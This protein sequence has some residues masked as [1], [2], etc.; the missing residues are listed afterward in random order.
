MESLCAWQQR[1]RVG[2]STSLTE[3]GQHMSLVFYCPWAAI[4][5]FASETYEGVISRYSVYP[6]A[7][8]SRVR[9]F[10]LNA[11]RL[12]NSGSSKRNFVS[13]V[14]CV[15][16]STSSL[17]APQSKLPHSILLDRRKCRIISAGEKT[18]FTS[19]SYPYLDSPERPVPG[20]ALAV[21]EARPC[22]YRFRKPYRRFILSRMDLY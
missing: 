6:D 10:L 7:V 19:Q 15:S 14:S 20:A 18:R 11:F 4:S 8:C 17:R 9:F 1:A 5:P 13:C 21:N 16:L 3:G 22:R 2:I 12:A